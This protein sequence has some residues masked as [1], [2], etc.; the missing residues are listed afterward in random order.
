MLTVRLYF[1]LASFPSSLMILSLSVALRTTRLPEDLLLGFAE[2]SV[3]ILRAGR[4]GLNMAVVPRGSFESMVSLS[5][6]LQHRKYGMV[7]FKYQTDAFK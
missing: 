5:G 3:W 2:R 1:L 6:A 4:A 7:S